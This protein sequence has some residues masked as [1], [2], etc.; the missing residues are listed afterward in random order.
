MA[1][2]CS[3]HFGEWEYPVGVAIPNSF[4]F[5]GPF[6]EFG[7]HSNAGVEVHK[8]DDLIFQRNVGEYEVQGRVEAVFELIID[9][10]WGAGITTIACW[11]LF[12]LCDC[13]QEESNGQSQGP[14]SSSQQ[15]TTIVPASCPIYPTPRELLPSLET[16]LG[17]L[18]GVPW[19]VAEAG[20]RHTLTLR[21]SVPVVVPGTPHSTCGGPQSAAPRMLLFPYRQPVPEPM[22]STSQAAG[23]E[24]SLLATR[25]SHSFE[26][27]PVTAGETSQPP[28]SAAGRFPI[29]EEPEDSRI[30]ECRP[31][32]LLVNSGRFGLPTSPGSAGHSNRQLLEGRTQGCASV[33]EASR[34]KQPPPLNERHGSRTYYR[35]L[36]GEEQ[37]L[38]PPSLAGGR[39]EAAGS[40][41][42]DHISMSSP[43]FHQDSV[44]RGS[45]SEGEDRS[46]SHSDSP[47][48]MGEIGPFKGTSTG[49]WSTSA[50]LSAVQDCAGI[51]TQAGSVH[52][53]NLGSNQPSQRSEKGRSPSD[54]EHRVEDVVG[55]EW[56]PSIVNDRAADPVVLGVTKADVHPVPQ[57][58]IDAIGH[59]MEDERVVTEPTVQDG[60]LLEEVSAAFGVSTV[61]IISK[62]PRSTVSDPCRDSASVAQRLESQCHLLNGD[63][64]LGQGK[65]AEPMRASDSLHPISE[66]RPDCSSQSES[67]ENIQDVGNEIGLAEPPVRT[68]TL[69]D[70]LGVCSLN[71]EDIKGHSASEEDS[72]CQTGEI[73]NKP[74]DKLR[75][76]GRNKDIPDCDFLLQDRLNNT[77]AVCVGNKENVGSREE[78]MRF[79]GSESTKPNRGEEAAMAIEPTTSSEELT[80]DAHRDEGVNCGH[81]QTEGEAGELGSACQ[82]EVETE[83][84]RA[85]PALPAALESPSPGTKSDLLNNRESQALSPPCLP[86]GGTSLV[87]ADSTTQRLNSNVNTLAFDK[88]HLLNTL[89][90]KA[91]IP[92]TSPGS[93][94]SG[95]RR[96]MGKVGNLIDPEAS[97]T[98]V[99]TAVT[100]E[101]DVS[102]VGGLSVNIN[103]AEDGVAFTEEW[104]G[105]ASN[106]AMAECLVPGN[107]LPKVDLFPH[108]TETKDESPLTI[109]ATAHMHSIPI[110]TCPTSDHSLPATANTDNDTLTYSNLGK[111]CCS[112]VVESGISDASRM[113]G[114]V[115][116]PGQ[117]SEGRRSCTVL[118]EVAR[119]SGGCVVQ[120][121]TPRNSSEPGDIT[122]LM[123]DVET[124]SELYSTDQRELETNDKT[125]G[126][127]PGS[128]IKSK[129]DPPAYT[130]F[131][132]N[133]FGS[134]GI[135]VEG[136]GRL[137]VT[138]L[139]VNN[140][141]VKKGCL[142]GA[143]SNMEHSVIGNIGGDSMDVEVPIVMD[144][145]M[146]VDPVSERA[147]RNVIEAS[148]LSN[149][150]PVPTPLELLSDCSVVSGTCRGEGSVDETP[151]AKSSAVTITLGDTVGEEVEGLE[152]LTR[153]GDPVATCAQ[154]EVKDTLAAHRHD[155]A[156]VSPCIRAR[157]VHWRV[158]LT[159]V[160]P[161][162]DGN[163]DPLMQAESLTCTAEEESYQQNRCE[164]PATDEPPHRVRIP[165][166]PSNNTESEASLQGAVGVPRSESPLDATPVTSGQDVVDPPRAARP[167]EQGATDGPQTMC[168]AGLDQPSLV[169]VEGKGDLLPKCRTK[170]VPS[171]A[172]EL[173]GEPCDHFTA[174]DK[175]K[176][177]M[178]PV[179]EELEKFPTGMEYGAARPGAI[180]QMKN[181]KFDTEDKPAKTQ[182][183]SLSVPDAENCNFSAGP[184]A[185]SGQSEVAEA[186]ESPES[187]SGTF[188]P[189]CMTAGAVQH[190]DGGVPATLRHLERV[191]AC[192]ND[193]EVKDDSAGSKKAADVCPT[194]FSGEHSGKKVNP[195]SA[196]L[197]NGDS[198]PE[199]HL[200]WDEASAA[201]AQTEQRLT[202]NDS[203][204]DSEFESVSEQS[205]KLI[206]SNP[207]PG[208]RAQEACPFVGSV[209][210]RELGLSSGNE[211]RCLGATDTNLLE[212]SMADNN[213][214]EVTEVRLNKTH[215]DKSSKF[216]LDC[217][218]KV[219]TA[220]AEEGELAKSFPYDSQG[221]LVRGQSSVDERD[222][223]ENVCGKSMVRQDAAKNGVLQ[224]CSLLRSEES[225]EELNS[226][227]GSELSVRLG[228]SLGAEQ[229][230]DEG[231][232]ESDGMFGSDG[233]CW[234]MEG[235]EMTVRDDAEGFEDEIS[236]DKGSMQTEVRAVCIRVPDSP[237][238]RAV[239]I[240]VA[241][242]PQPM[243]F[244]AVK[245][246]RQANR[247]VGG[248]SQTSLDAEGKLVPV[249]CE[250]EERLADE[251]QEEIKKS[252]V[253]E[254][255]PGWSERRVG[256]PPA[257]EWT[258]SPMASQSP[259]T[260]QQTL[261]LGLAMAS[262]KC[263]VTRTL[264]TERR[265]K[266]LGEERA[267]GLISVTGLPE[268]LDSSDGVG[269]EASEG[270]REH[271]VLPGVAPCEL[272]GSNELTEQTNEE[273]EES[274]LEEELEE[275]QSEKSEQEEE[276]KEELEEEQSEEEEEEDCSVPSEV[277]FSHIAMAVRNEDDPLPPSGIVMHNA[278]PCEGER[279]SQKTCSLTGFSEEL[280]VSGD[281]SPELEDQ[282]LEENQRGNSNPNQLKQQF[283]FSREAEGEPAGFV[284]ELPAD[285]RE[286][287]KSKLVTL[288]EKGEPSGNEIAT[289]QPECT[290]H[291]SEWRDLKTDPQQDHEVP[292]QNLNAG[293]EQETGNEV[294]SD[295]GQS[296]QEETLA[297][298]SPFN[299]KPQALLSESLDLIPIA[300][301]RQGRRT[302]PEPEH[303]DTRWQDMELDVMGMGQAVVKHRDLSE[304][305]SVDLS[306]S[307]AGVEV[308]SMIVSSSPEYLN[309]QLSE[310]ESERED[311]T[312]QR[313]NGQRHLDSQELKRSRTEET[314]SSNSAGASPSKRTC[315]SQQTGT[316]GFVSAERLNLSLLSLSKELRRHRAWH[317][318]RLVQQFFTERRASWER[319]FYSKARVFNRRAE[320]ARIVREFFKTPVVQ[321]QKEAINTLHRNVESERLTVVNPCY[322]SEI[323]GCRQE[324]RD[325]EELLCQ[326]VQHRDSVGC[327]LDY[328]CAA[329]GTAA[330]SA[331][332]PSPSI[333]H[334]LNT[335]VNLLVGVMDDLETSPLQDAGKCDGEMETVQE[336]SWGNVLHINSPDSRKSHSD[337]RIQGNL[338]RMQKTSNYGFPSTLL[339]KGSGIC[340]EGS[341]APRESQTGPWS[342][343]QRSSSADS[344]EGLESS[345]SNL[346][347]SQEVKEVPGGGVG[348]EEDAGDVSGHLLQELSKTSGSLMSFS[349]ARVVRDGEA[350]KD[351]ECCAPPA[352]ESIDYAI[353]GVT[354]IFCDHRPSTDV[355]PPSPALCT[356]P[357]TS[358]PGHLGGMKRFSVAELSYPVHDNRGRSHDVAE[359]FSVT[360]PSPPVHD[361]RCRSHDVVKDCGVTEPPPPDHDNL[362][363]SYGVG[364]TLLNVNCVGSNVSPLGSSHNVQSLRSQIGSSIA[365][366]PVSGGFAESLPKFRGDCD[367]KQGRECL[368]DRSAPSDWRD[369]SLVAVVHGCEPDVQHADRDWP[370]A[371]PRRRRQAGR[372]VESLGTDFSPSRSPG[373]EAERFGMVAPPNVSMR[374][375]VRSQS[376]PEWKGEPST[377]GEIAIRETG[378]EPEAKTKVELLEDSVS[379]RA[380][381]SI[382]R[383]WT[384]FPK[385]DKEDTGK[386]G[387]ITPVA[388][389]QTSS[390]CFAEDRVVERG[391][392]LLVVGDA[393]PVLAWSQNPTE[394]KIPPHWGAADPGRGGEPG[395]GR[396]QEPGLGWGGDPGTSGSSSVADLSSAVSPPPQ[397]SLA[398]RHSLRAKKR[399]RESGDGADGS[400]QLMFPASPCPLPPED[401]SH[402]DSISCVIIISDSEE[403]PPL[404][405]VKQESE[406]DDEAGDYPY[407]HGARGSVARA[408]G[409][410]P[411]GTPSGGNV[412]SERVKGVSHTPGASCRRGAL[413]P[414][415]PEQ[416]PA[417]RD[418]PSYPNLSARPLAEVSLA[419]D[420]HRLQEANRSERSMPECC[421][422]LS[423]GE[424]HRTGPPNLQID[425][426]PPIEL[427]HLSRQR[428]NPISLVKSESVQSDLFQSQDPPALFDFRNTEFPDRL[429]L[430]YSLDDEIFPPPELDYLSDS[431]DNSDREGSRDGFTSLRKQLVDSSGS[432]SVFSGSRPP[433][434]HGDGKSCAELSLSQRNIN[435]SCGWDLS[436]CEVRA[437][438][439][440]TPEGHSDGGQPG[441]AFWE[442][443]DGKRAE[444]SSPSVVAAAP[445]FPSPGGPAESLW[446]T[447]DQDVTG[448]LREC[449]LLL[450]CTS[451]TLQA[452]GIAQAH[453]KEWK[454][455]I[456]EL[457]KQT[458]P[459]PTH[460]AVIGDTGSGKSSLLNALLDEEAVLPTSAM[461]ACTAVAV[462]V[463]HNSHND[464]YCAEVEFFSEEEWQN[465]LFSLLR[466]MSDKNGRLKKRRPDPNSEAS[467]AYS[468]VKAVYGKILPY[469][470]LKEIRDVTSYLGKTEIISETRARDFRFKVQRFIDSRTDDSRGCRGGEFWPIVKRVRIRVPRS[471]VL[472][473]GAV[474]VDLPGIRDSNTARNNIAKEYLTN[475]DAVWIVAN[476]TR[477]IDDKTAK[478]MLDE[479]LRRQLLMD[480]QYGRI[481]FICTK[482]DSHN[483]TEI[484][485]ALPQTS[486]CNLL[487]DEIVELKNEIEKRQT[488]QLTWESELERLQV[489]TQIERR[490]SRAKQLECAIKHQAS[491]L[492][493]LHRSMNLKR[494]E[495]SM[496]S[497]KARNFFCKRNIRHNFKC[498]LQELKRQAK[499]EELDSE[500][501]KEESDEE[502][503]EEEDN[504]DDVVHPLLTGGPEPVLSRDGQLHVFTVSSTEYLKLRDKLLRDGP[505]QVFSS[506]E[507]T[508]IPAVQRFVHQITLARRALATE[509]VIRKV[510]TLI[511]HVVAYLTNRRAQDASYQ[512]QV[513]VT[514]QTCLS[515]VEGLFHQTAEDCNRKIGSSFSLIET[516]LNNGMRLA[517]KSSK[518]SVLRWGSQPP[519]GYLYSTYKA[520]C[521]R[522]GTFT[523][524]SC[525]TID[526]NEELTHP[527]FTPVMVIWSEVFSDS[528]LCSKSVFQHLQTF[529]VDVLENLRHFFSD[530][531]WQ[532]QRIKGDPQPVD[533]ILR[534]QLS[535]VEAKLQN[536]T[537]ML[538]VDIT[539]R[540]RNISR[541]LTPSVQKEMTP[542][543][544][545]CQLQT[546][547]GSFKRMKSHLEK[548]V[549]KHGD[550]IFCT[551]CRKLMEQ[552]CLLQGVIYSHLKQVLSEIKNDLLVQFEPI[553]KPV[554][555]IDEII[556]K[557][558]SVCARIGNLCR[559]SHIDFTM[560]K[561]EEGEAE[562]ES[563]TSLREQEKL[564]ILS[565]QK[566]EKF[567]GQARIMK[568]GELDV[569]PINPV[570]ISLD[571]VILC[572]EVSGSPRR[573]VI[574]FQS[575]S[576]CDFCPS[577]HFF[578]LYL[579][580]QRAE[581]T[582]D[583][584]RC[585]VVILDEQQTSA[586][587]GEWMEVVR[588]HLR[589]SVQLRKLELCQG[590]E[591]LQSLGVIFQ[592]ANT[593]TSEG[594]GM[595]LAAPEPIGELVAF[596]S[597]GPFASTNQQSRKRSWSEPA[598]G[599]DRL[600]LQHTFQCPPHWQVTSFGTESEL[601]PPIL[602]KEKHDEQDT[603]SSDWVD[604]SVPP[605]L[606]WEMMA[607]PKGG[608]FKNP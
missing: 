540:Q 134:V 341:D 448:Q 422:D 598:T 243:S 175:T 159:T 90:L 305:E 280:S 370:Q 268:R 135:S 404:K 53:E 227:T 517:V 569:S 237:E 556:P 353:G 218:R 313:L 565:I 245:S 61:G 471:A 501:E 528:P 589:D 1:S 178:N 29:A 489:C 158:S 592:G 388:S 363:R 516:Q 356:D 89:G 482:S 65:A 379:Q 287:A 20:I 186:G 204:H 253:P 309:L 93:T 568:I 397:L 543:Y 147:G 166:C 434:D 493:K 364:E 500:E 601:L 42:T 316:E 125:R 575:L 98:V 200:L 315:M 606:K 401:E 75:D 272:M 350:G 510:A 5:N 310:S 269:L 213:E 113:Q 405:A 198:S 50:Y 257:S 87:N 402:G 79:L 329:D 394:W 560:P 220:D 51:G 215:G 258:G 454:E 335:E 400:S 449:G 464:C 453:V 578:I 572:F 521:G 84:H 203:I 393:H 10:G 496:N 378:T 358:D 322:T 19:P 37:T 110:T 111:L 78:P 54:G 332:D 62:S 102:D 173:L 291:A 331:T 567:L 504:D 21:S 326:E 137:C 480:G 409:S 38:A 468:R 236:S 582:G 290:K 80:D 184:M 509:M 242:S 412:Y 133:P 371:T 262:S 564:E 154:L 387:I 420:S 131:P 580:P 44:H 199:N 306:N 383:L 248:A 340:L 17:F 389:S 548:Y 475:C 229:D 224:S 561:I 351:S 12:E 498:G 398:N 18:Q 522:N 2:W 377:E 330:T 557:L 368:T 460:I 41:T 362:G 172:C 425:G 308:G 576:T 40:A 539:A 536:F 599:I 299:R 64:H 477:A 120:G 452:E 300:E 428:P 97:S 233:L 423:L 207:D 446:A 22:G 593:W 140:A 95:I 278:H 194:E 282:Y 128:D 103:L 318:G 466:D 104:S 265:E 47:V 107:S 437:A 591:R 483:V 571:E 392:A 212:Q 492:D 311:I 59:D 325:N 546:G 369:S 583:H 447:S 444:A 221:D 384:G 143:A 554:K 430:P 114:E 118:G 465:E 542:A 555:I 276:S 512:A 478:D 72:N 281:R 355:S 440:L 119:T 183:C 499:T 254:E 57:L 279:V 286:D 277:D 359:Y 206:L 190:H 439:R 495:L 69:L 415:L 348:M 261:Q 503:D 301:I 88:L 231:S 288:D 117:H 193:T 43:C 244:S 196:G 211:Q 502:E 566:L 109:K 171:E 77:T 106:L 27:S 445:H 551:A 533:Y 347:D 255:C 24:T 164:G 4:L 96:Q 228:S 39:T 513:R 376:S 3:V 63:C 70:A 234:S 155:G 457:Q 506:I 249:S 529:K 240:T 205:N 441:S 225:A 169:C 176:A 8:E 518:S 426:S 595:P 327:G 333:P 35:P 283:D 36:G 32:F 485:R 55:M 558:E 11:L 600:N 456:E 396:V 328:R 151:S 170:H 149:V 307:E 570:E 435:P 467:M 514:V 148:D 596:H 519:R 122:V 491:E 581:V 424:E 577:M 319:R 450:Q 314:L 7:I 267:K 361:N 432:D 285:Q 124:Q 94:S 68:E 13:Q 494:R 150:S 584:P 60:T 365:L 241:T 14:R 260:M 179:R 91:E 470:E 185:A 182:R 214:A 30:A 459:P 385:S 116:T 73:L 531:K 201:L 574:P 391:R 562:P 210:K 443:R 108:F 380:G 202:M 585:N 141:T 474:L 34:S 67:K 553:L 191:H 167:R 238:E 139:A 121:N 52:E 223:E 247:E 605:V 411:S 192:E 85:E 524:P 479:S 602:K 373:F 163:L 525:G 337:K 146:D 132:N 563:T 469:N 92:N 416:Y 588:D 538:M 99:E 343:L 144:E 342:L 295:C 537:L 374:D 25:A 76:G 26:V 511:S 386:D 239:C 165:I 487:E 544:T 507:D 58:D 66:Q 414:S 180:S 410:L 515:R 395:S 266:L 427:L 127:H 101:E 317:I 264:E 302:N 284:E 550:H 46:V 74:V 490:D 579:Q 195:S 168:E 523:S 126:L 293:V 323:A 520:T 270:S 336:N 142:H 259:D 157:D 48:L 413:R 177:H 375:P 442:L 590:V 82:S 461:R 484:L 408:P 162:D 216:L 497:I 181:R 417:P 594:D 436:Q 145:V 16:F 115:S 526:F 15:Q 174:V 321:P 152:S 344:H 187:P 433:V 23:R 604:R 549:Q 352:D 312:S 586:D 100:H 406:S 298:L 161:G 357:S 81:N 294:T 481:A 45:S 49:G 535:A 28:A 56:A 608:E 136:V 250:K 559:R 472:R 217:P 138:A 403:Q 273:E 345:G 292:K 486:D 160:T 545:V 530:L 263:E 232:M 275:E 473:T 488:E 189:S 222:E 226:V 381:D 607:N 429:R 367:G 271:D 153:A 209:F 33:E 71:E 418:S 390:V 360:E 431:C 156:R 382:E 208:L 463:S 534:Q 112:P 252:Q 246:S 438:S 9:K 129:P 372:S 462:E 188:P 197:G 421:T 354:G 476:V 86:I 130:P 419:T 123:E 320:V 31:F 6:P 105:V 541:I 552:L 366:D 338:D 303:A 334:S 256:I 527:M 603:S 304:K 274:E 235:S 573:C 230:Q 289:T 349:S 219:D 508:E 339:A 458:I 297:Q 296:Q 399:I 597:A 532:L 83:V 547:S 451:Q 251:R 346:C 587:F 324:P 455:Q 407:G 505:P